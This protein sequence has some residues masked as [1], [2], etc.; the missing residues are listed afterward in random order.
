MPPYYLLG[1]QRWSTLGHV[2]G[3]AAFYLF[4]LF[5]LRKAWQRT[6]E[7]ALYIWYGLA[8]LCMYA[9][10]C[11]LALRLFIPSRQ[12]EYAMD[13]A[14][15]LLFGAGL[16]WFWQ[17]RVLRFFPRHAQHLSVLLV[18][19]LALAGSVRLHQQGL[20]DYSEYA[21][22]YST[23]RALPKD[24]LLAGH[25]RLMDAVHTFGLRN[26]LA[27]EKLAHPWSLGYWARYEPRLRASLD[28][29]YAKDLRTLVDV[30]ERYGITH[31]IVV[32]RHFED[33]FLQDVPLFAPYNDYIR[34]LAARPG[35]FLLAPGGPLPG[36]EVQ[37]GVRLIPLADISVPAPQANAVP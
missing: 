10:A 9:L 2:L 11:A 37:P 31:L 32:K 12:L 29:V 25:P 17:E 6:G 13:V 28:A 8:C 16:G 26:V 15:C 21:P 24:A 19:F 36:L 22:L 33:A 35:A 4:F 20:T 3:V 14:L 5:C 7:L 27:S 30:R 1:M 18:C 23:A 34:S